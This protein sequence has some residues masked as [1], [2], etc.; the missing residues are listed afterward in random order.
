MSIAAIDFPE[1]QAGSVQHLSFAQPVSLDGFDL[2][3]WRPAAI[4]EVYS[5]EC[6][7]EGRPVL[8]V[9]DSQRVFSHTRYWREEFGEFLGR[10]GT[11]VVL[12]PGF[13]TMGLHTVQDI[14][15][16]AVME[17][18]PGYREL[19]HS[20][21]NAAP[22]ACEEGEPF[23]Q[24]FNAHGGYFT[25]RARFSPVDAQS[26]ATVAGTEDVCAV[27]QY[28]HPG[29]VLVLPELSDAASSKE[30]SAIVEALDDLSARLRLDARISS[31]VGAR[32]VVTQR[33]R[34]LRQELA[35]I[36][37]QRRVLQAREAALIRELADIAFFG[38]LEYGDRVGVIDASMQ[39]MHALGAYVQF[40]V[41]SADTLM[42][43]LTD[44]VCVAV[45][46][47]D[48]DVTPS[49][50]ISHTLNEKT[51]PWAKELNRP[52]TPVALYIGGN[53]RG[54]DAAAE[55]LELL[56]ERHPAIAWL[57]GAQLQ[58]AYAS[59][60]FDF[61]DQVLQMAPTGCPA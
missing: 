39:V 11:L 60:D 30:V 35:D 57:S 33:E 45:V 61:L 44:K 49:C 3:I 25:A 52:V 20:T 28:C 14:V 6:W 51:G 36:S 58:H 16:Y 59:R 54:P 31:A 9:R 1:S 7:L 43:E 40:G 27:Y 34:S 38:Q 13:I 41:G 22:V 26:V 53:K 12:A 42:F 23:R 32:P 15:P 29:R 47:D 21:C 48:A 56:R 24:F 55:E 18:L 37:G 5:T 19:H 46:L 2:V 4:A 10:G 50:D 17:A 8:D